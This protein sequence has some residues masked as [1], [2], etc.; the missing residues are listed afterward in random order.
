MAKLF[1]S[2]TLQEENLTVLEE[3]TISSIIDGLY[4]EPHNSEVAA[5]DVSKDTGI[6]MRSLRGILASLTNKGYITI[7]D[8]SGGFP[9]IY[10]NIDHWDLHPEWG[11]SNEYQNYLQSKRLVK[12]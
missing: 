2:P 10:L 7:K 11:S 5:R 8:N 6:T 4:S 9:V 3:R 1:S 12:C